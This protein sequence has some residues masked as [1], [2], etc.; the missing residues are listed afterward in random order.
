MKMK[1][2]ILPCRANHILEIKPRIARIARVERAILIRAISVI[3]GLTG[4]FARRLGD[5]C[6]PWCAI[7][8][9]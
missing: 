2:R 4:R 7:E 1:L 8:V 9:K 3:R 5:R 6:N